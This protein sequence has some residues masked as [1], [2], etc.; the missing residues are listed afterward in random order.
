MLDCTV[1][2]SP[3]LPKLLYR[4]TSD[5]TCVCRRGDPSMYSIRG[6]KWNAR[7][8]LLVL[9]RCSTRI[10]RIGTISLQNVSRQDPECHQYSTMSC[11]TL[12]PTSTRVTTQRCRHAHVQHAYAMKSW[13]IAIGQLAAKA[14]ASLTITPGSQR[15]SIRNCKT[16]LVMVHTACIVEYIF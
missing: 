10:R 14:D 4:L 3:S 12:L 15:D 11:I 13:R 8:N 16:L 2:L 6:T 1:F 7:F 5:S 9:R